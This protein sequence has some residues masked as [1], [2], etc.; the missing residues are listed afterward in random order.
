[1]TFEKNKFQISFHFQGDY[2]RE[3]F[4]LYGDETDAPAEPQLPEWCFEEEE[5]EDDLGGGGNGAHNN[6]TGDEGRAGAGSRNRRQDKQIGQ[7]WH[8][9]GKWGNQWDSQTSVKPTWAPC[10]MIPWSDSHPRST[11]GGS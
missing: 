11:A 3:L 2:L 9:H 4:K 10:T 8:G 5:E 6:A 1:M 7:R